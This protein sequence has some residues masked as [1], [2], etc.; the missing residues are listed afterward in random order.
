LSRYTNMAAVPLFWNT[1]MA[2][3]TLCENALLFFEVVV[4]VVVVVVNA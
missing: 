1:N 2:A 3:M 4:V